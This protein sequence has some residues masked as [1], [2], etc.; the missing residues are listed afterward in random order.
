MGVE[1]VPKYDI[2]VK[3][4]EYV[5]IELDKMKPHEQL[6][7]R[8]LE[9]FIESVTGSGIFWKP[10]LL[11]KIPGTDEYLIVDGHHRWAGLQK[12][13]AKRA[14]SVILDYFDEGVKVY[15][16]YPAFKGDVN[17]VIER[18][19][20]E[21]LEVIEDE[22]AEE[23]AEKGE[24]AF[25]LIGEK[26]FAIPGGLE[27]QKKVSKVL[28]EMDQ[29]KEIELVYYGLK[30]DAKADM[31]KGEIDYVFI[32]K[33]PTKEEVMELVKRGEVFS[34]KTTRH[35]LPFIPDKIDVKLED[36]F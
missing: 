26:S 11:A 27:E 10:M 20:A 31:E 15:T 23:K 9:D 35:V 7:Q 34:P 33:A 36:L 3:K 6:V 19:K 25:A 2:P 22:K 5:F 8:E 29:A 12:L 28:D 21:G 30:E 16:W 14:P 4:V 24:I 1:K 17:K 32:R 13:G 18:L